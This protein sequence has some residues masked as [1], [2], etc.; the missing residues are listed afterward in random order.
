MNSP[1]DRQH[2]Q[3]MHPGSARECQECVKA[4]DLLYRALSPDMEFSEAFETWISHRVLETVNE[5]LKALRPVDIDFISAKTERDYRVCAE[6]LG[7]FFGGQRIRSIRPPHVE[8][9]QRFRGVNPESDRG[10]WRCVQRRG[11]KFIDSGAHV[12]FETREQVEAWVKVKG[13][14]YEV[15]QSLWAK[16]AGANCIR[17]EIALL[18]R[19]LEAAKL[20][21]EADKKALLKV[22]FQQCELDRA[23]SPDRQ[24]RFLHAAARLPEWRVIYHYSIVALQTTAG[25]NEMRSLRLGDYFRERQPYIQIN[26]MG[27]K[28]RYRQRV[29][30]LPTEEAV[31]A[32][33]G[34]VERARERGSEGPAD[35]L[36]PIQ[37]TPTRYNPTRPMTDSGLRKPWNEV[38]VSAN[39]PELRMYDL[40]H[41]GITRMAERGVPLAVAMARA[42][43]MTPQMQRRYTAISVAAQREWGEHVWSDSP[44]GNATASPIVGR[45]PPQNDRPVNQESQLFHMVR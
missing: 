34:L 44:F 16:Q 5:G 31:L 6:A 27:A 3:K 45:K 23:M 28:N 4:S 25:T 8:M 7:K 38:R 32:M 41:T 12:K 35:F 14:S 9:Y 39:E 20:W 24:H 33:D 17:K 18:V 21:G 13:L 30:S 40:R 11:D 22:R 29:I 36:F 43:H 37:E 1:Q 42:G 26:R 19:I 10:V 15:R 2:I